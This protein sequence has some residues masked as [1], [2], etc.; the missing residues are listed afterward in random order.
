[1]KKI[2]QNNCKTWYALIDCKG[3]TP[4]IVSDLYSSEADLLKNVKD[5]S[6][7]MTTLEDLQGD[8]SPMICTIQLTNRFI[9]SNIDI[10]DG[11]Q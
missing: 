3:V 11:E 4:E 10:V 6:D 9:R 1:M 5:D 8:K 2:K 7:S